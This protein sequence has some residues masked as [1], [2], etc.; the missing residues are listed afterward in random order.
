MR[1]PREATGSANK[2]VRVGV[3][4]CAVSRKTHRQLTSAN[5]LP[6]TL[7]LAGCGSLGAPRTA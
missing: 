2:L 1:L 7:W 6:P 4:I 3:N 5:S